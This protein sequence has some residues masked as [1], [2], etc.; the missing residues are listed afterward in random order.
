MP[1]TIFEERKR[2]AII[3]LGLRLGPVLDAV[4][5]RFSAVG[6]PPILDPALLPWVA[7]IERNWRTIRTEADRVLR[8]RARIPPLRRISR[9]HDRITTDDNWRSFFLWGYGLKAEENCRRCPETAALV[10]RIP[11]LQT[12]L[13]SLLSP[14]THIPRHTGVTKAILTCHL[15]LR[16]PAARARCHIRVADQD[17]HWREGEMFVFDDMA[18]HEV[19]ND[20]EEDRVV[21][22]LHIKRPMRFPGTLLRDGFLA[23]VRHSPFIQDARHAIADWDQAAAGNQRG[24]VVPP[25]E[26]PSSAPPQPLPR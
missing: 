11:G 1:N 18:P 19:W 12:A 20:T 22:M 25:D 15:G 7:E 8:E 3:W 9:D 14:G 16:V 4:L 23:A 13:F 24:D 17:Y 10:A 26:A 6:N 2:A 21:L 5:A